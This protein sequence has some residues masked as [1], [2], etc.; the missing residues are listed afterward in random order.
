MLPVANPL[1]EISY[2]FFRESR[3]LS[4]SRVRFQKNLPVAYSNPPKQMRGPRTEKG[5][6]SVETEAR[7][8]LENLES[9]IA[10]LAGG[11]FADLYSGNQLT[12]PGLATRVLTSPHLLDDQLGPLSGTNDLGRHTGSR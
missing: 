5:R 10:R 4:T 11:D 7:G 2:G 8:L 1:A 12:M 3:S 9:I 6:D